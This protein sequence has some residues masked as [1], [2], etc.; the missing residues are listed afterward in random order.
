MCLFA[1]GCRGKL[2]T[3]LTFCSPKTQDSKARTQIRRH[4]WKLLLSGFTCKIACNDYYEFAAFRGESPAINLMSSSGGKRADDH[5]LN[6]EILSDNGPSFNYWGKILKVIFFMI[7][8]CLADN[9][10]DDGL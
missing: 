2:V 9:Y 3:E 4:K 8:D 7:V 6:P 10:C 1:F 5:I